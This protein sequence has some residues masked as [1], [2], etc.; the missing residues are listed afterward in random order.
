MAVRDATAVALIR[1]FGIVISLE[2]YLVHLSKNRATSLGSTAD[3]LGR[4]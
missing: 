3:Q 2:R 1:R 4:R